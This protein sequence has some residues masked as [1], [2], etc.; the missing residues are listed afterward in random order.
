MG[1]LKWERK[2][3]DIVLF[4]D[5]EDEDLVLNELRREKFRKW[6]YGTVRPITR[7]GGKIRGVGTII[8]FD[9]LLSRMMPPVKSKNTIREPLRDYS[10]EMNRGWASV[11]YRAHDDDFS[12]ILWE[13]SHSEK[14]LRKIRA[15]YAEMGMLDIYGQEYLNNPID[16]STAYFRRQDFLETKIEERETRKTYYAASDFAIGEQEAFRPE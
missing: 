11:R 6:F 8:G 13:E 2:R 4:D 12:N 1:G 15:D 5:V 14:R 16:P 3:P 10:S 7:E 9:S